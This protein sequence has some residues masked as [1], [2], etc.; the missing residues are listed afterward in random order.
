VCSPEDIDALIDGTIRQFGR[1]DVLVNNAGI[2]PQSRIEELDPALFET[3]M[4]VNVNAVYHGCRA[5]WPVMK[6]QGGGVIVSISSLASVDPFPG[7]TAY[8]AAKAW[9]SAWT[10]GLADEGRRFGIRVYSVAPGAVETKMLRDP[11]PDFPADQALQPSDVADVAW[12]LAQPECRYVTG[13]T[14]FVK[15]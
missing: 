3:I 12:A 1:I 7:F 10:R 11:F 8:G 4:S 15:K 14:V 13:Q 6:K 5:V 2:A 9:V